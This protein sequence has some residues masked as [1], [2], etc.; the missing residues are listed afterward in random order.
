MGVFLVVTRRMELSGNLERLQSVFMDTLGEVGFII[1]EVDVYDDRFSVAAVNKKRR[2][3]MTTTLM[4]LIWGHIPEK[5]M[6]VEL[7]ASGQDESIN[8]VLRCFPYM[9]TVDMEV[10][11]ETAQEEEKCRR[12]VDVFWNRILEKFGKNT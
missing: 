3:L 8:A 9:E 4:S 1:F 10:K 11:A 7:N 2:S 5:R 12:M 6:A